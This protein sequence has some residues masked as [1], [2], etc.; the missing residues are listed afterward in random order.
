M[1]IAVVAP[2]FPPYIGGME[3]YCYELANQLVKMGNV[4]TVLTTVPPSYPLENSSTHG[5]TVMRFRDLS[6]FA[7]HVSFGLSRF[8]AKNLSKFDFVIN[9]NYH[10]LLALQIAL[11]SPR[12]ML[13]RPHFHG[14]VGLTVERTA[15]HRLY[16]LA[17]ALITSRSHIII[18]ESDYEMDLFKA[19]FPR[20]V[21]RVVKIRG[22][23]NR[24][25]CIDKARIP[26]TILTVARLEN[27]KG[28]EDII[29]VLVYL[30]SYTLH[31][32]GDGPMKK[33]LVELASDLAVSS[34]VVFH[35]FVPTKVKNLMFCKMAV[36]VLL[37]RHESFG[38]AVG[39][40]L[41]AGQPCIVL[42]SNA[43]REWVNNTNCFGITDPVRPIQLAKLIEKVQGAA[44]GEQKAWTW[45]D[46]VRRLQS[47]MKLIE[48]VP[49]K[50]TR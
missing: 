48:F 37:S 32:V 27:Y 29:R 1:R 47:M 50:T 44:G 4:V 24:V 22:G 19:A 8:L 34:R 35:C 49:D 33:D 46:N 28:V 42:E 6:P 16:R 21:S 9:N 3:Q 31:V 26:N 17:G 7:P 20:A 43:L 36:M 38:T 13:F 25:D 39:E 45:D 10:S 2:R 14:T 23:I 15:L 30:P 41:S 11:S 5:Y 12:R 18:C 40:A